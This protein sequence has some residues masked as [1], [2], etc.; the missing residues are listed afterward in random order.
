LDSLNVAY[1]QPIEIQNIKTASNGQYMAELWVYVYEY[2]NGT[3]PGL[4]IIWDKHIKIEIAYDVNNNT[5]LTSIC[6]PYVDV[7]N[8]A[9]PL[10]F[11]SDK[12]KMGAWTFIRCSVNL[13]ANSF[14]INSLGEQKLNSTLI[15]RNSIS[16]TTKLYI[17]DNSNNDSYGIALLRELRLWTGMTYLYYDT[18]RM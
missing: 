10:Y 6:Y 8:N 7:S 5:N 18:S 3:F 13:N 15:N 12:M 4:N 2:A 9:V 17:N 1:Y 11:A 16:S 14:Y